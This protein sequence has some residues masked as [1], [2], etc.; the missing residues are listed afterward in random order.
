MFEDVGLWKR[1]RYFPRAARTW[2]RPWRANA[3]AVRDRR[4]HL[5]RLDAGQDRGR[6][7]DAAE[8]MNR[9]YINAWT[10]LEP[11]R[12]RYGAAAARG[13]LHLR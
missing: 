7:P 12:C 1:A 10:K 13:R 5:R 9:I 6:R 3:C 2:A 4:R 8:F 11:G